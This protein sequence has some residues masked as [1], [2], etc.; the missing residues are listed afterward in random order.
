VHVF[1]VASD[2]KP[3]SLYVQRGGRGETVASEPLDDRGDGWELVP[4]GGSITLGAPVR[5]RVPQP[6]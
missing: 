1:R 3:P 6:A 5:A 2:G 4:C